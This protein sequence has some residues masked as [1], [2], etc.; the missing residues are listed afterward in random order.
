M[1][2][3]RYEILEKSKLDKSVVIQFSLFS[4]VCNFGNLLVKEYKR[5]LNFKILFILKINRLVS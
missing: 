5:K 4:L 1:P 2:G 3:K